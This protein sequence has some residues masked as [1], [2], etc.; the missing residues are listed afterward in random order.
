MVAEANATPRRSAKL[1]PNQLENQRPPR[2][3]LT[4]PQQ[5]QVT[6]QEWLDSLALGDAAR[7]HITGE[8]APVS[9][10]VVYK[11]VGFSQLAIRLEDARLIKF[12]DELRLRGGGEMILPPTGVPINGAA[13]RG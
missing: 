1:G 13:L 5:T 2:P 7:V 3:T 6:R 4:E 8:G 12:I 9:G 10:F 11:N